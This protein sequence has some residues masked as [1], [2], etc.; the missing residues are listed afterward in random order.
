MQPLDYDRLPAKRRHIT[1]EILS[2]FM[3]PLFLIDAAV[4]FLP[5]MP[6]SFY[7]PLSTI[8][9]FGVFVGIAAVFCAVLPWIANGERIYIVV[10]GI[11]LVVVSG[12]VS[13]TAHG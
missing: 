11:L 13:L 2:L 7:Q 8:A 6:W 10:A 9:A 12:C 5:D 4:L 3:L 1:A